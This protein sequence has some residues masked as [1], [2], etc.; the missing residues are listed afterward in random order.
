M[1]NFEDDIEIRQSRYIYLKGVVAAILELSN[2]H[3]FMHFIK[4]YLSIDAA[5]VVSNIAAPHC[6]VGTICT[7]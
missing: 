3:N 6:T 5:P 4:N 2:S 7:S 1:N